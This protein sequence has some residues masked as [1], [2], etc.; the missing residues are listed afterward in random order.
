MIRH[1]T[2]SYEMVPSAHGRGLAD[3]DIPNFDPKTYKNILTKEDVDALVNFQLAK[4]QEAGEILSVRSELAKHQQWEQ[5]HHRWLVV[6]VL[7]KE[8]EGEPQ[9]WEPCQTVLL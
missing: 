2:I 5:E 9:Q 6:T 8:K 3:E 4:I 7:Y 1:K